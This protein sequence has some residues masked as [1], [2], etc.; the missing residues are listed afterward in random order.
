MKGFYKAALPV[1]TDLVTGFGKAFDDAVDIAD[2]MIVSGTAHLVSA[3]DT[4]AKGFVSAV[5]SVAAAIAK[6]GASLIAGAPAAAARGGQG[7]GAPPV[8]DGMVPLLQRYEMPPGR[9]NSPII[10]VTNYLDGQRV[11]GHI[12]RTI[13]RTGSGPVQG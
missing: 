3:L 5:G 12:V 13:A 11:A 2:N 6:V 8:K 1:L 9:G 10:H 7:S 4:F